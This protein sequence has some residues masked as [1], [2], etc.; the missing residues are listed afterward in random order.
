M[1]RL[2]AQSA[3]KERDW[4]AYWEIDGSGRPSSA[5]YLSDSAFL[6]NLPANFDVLDAIVRMWRWTGD[7]TYRNNPAFQRFFHITIGDYIKAGQLTPDTI[8]KRQPIG[9]QRQAEGRFVHSRGI[10]SY[11][12]GSSDFIFGGLLASQYRAIQSFSHSERSQ[13]ARAIASFHRRRNRP[14]TRSR[15]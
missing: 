10:P 2:F 12:E 15:P 1:L 14:R 5:D 11:S 13:R 3:A 7:D 6:F 9:N 4:A 8:L